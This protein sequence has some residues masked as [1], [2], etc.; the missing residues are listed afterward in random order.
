MQFKVKQQETKKFLQSI[1]ILFEFYRKRAVEVFQYLGTNAKRS[2]AFSGSYLGCS[3]NCHSVNV[4]ICLK[5]ILQKSHQ[6]H[7]AVQTTS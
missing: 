2:S 4:N 5:E 1:Y 6:A 3:I 7:F